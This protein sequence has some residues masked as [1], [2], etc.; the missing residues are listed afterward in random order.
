MKSRDKNLGSKQLLEQ[1]PHYPADTSCDSH[2]TRAE[3]HMTTCSGCGWGVGGE[4]GRRTRGD[5]SNVSRPWDPSG[6]SGCGLRAP[7][8]RL[9][10][11]GTRLPHLV[12][13]G[14]TRIGSL[15]YSD[16]ENVNP[17]H[18]SKRGNSVTAITCLFYIQL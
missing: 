7:S 5:G 12:L 13:R 6:Q 10:P 9:P 8:E 16:N 15:G 14:G 4:G 17:L 1:L 2:M 11:V 18:P 3:D